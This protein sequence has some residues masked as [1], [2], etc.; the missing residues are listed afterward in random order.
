MTQGQD[1]LLL[2]YAGV[3]GALL[4][5]GFVWKEIRNVRRNKQRSLPFPND[6]RR[7]GDRRNVDKDHHEMASASH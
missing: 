1:L 3:A 2:L 7:G 5:A 4:L 6:R